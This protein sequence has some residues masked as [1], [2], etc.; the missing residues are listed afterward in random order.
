MFHRLLPFFTLFLISATASAWAQNQLV[1]RVVA[2][3]NDEAITQSELDL[4]LRPMFKE[5]R[6]QYKGDELGRQFNEVRLKLL[7]QMI[8]DRLVFQQAKSQS[9]TVDEEEIDQHIDELKSR[10]PSQEAF[11]KELDEQHY[12]L[13]ELRENYRRQIMI[14]KLHDQEIRAHVVISPRKIE[15]YYKEHQSEFAEE[16]QNKIRSITIRK[17]QEAIDKGILDEAAKKKIESIEK[18]IRAGE[19]F[20]KLAQEFSEDGYAKEGGRVGLVKRNE[21]MPEINDILFQLQAGGISP[22]LETSIGYHLF[23]VEEKKLSR[24]PPFEEVKEKIRTILFRKAAEERF[25]E[26]MNELKTRA[27][28]SIR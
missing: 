17:G 28:I 20:E 13:N 7:D 2:V 27:Y 22:V 14:R 23:K 18:R 15:D 12:N 9:I 26:W 21:M 5:L 6:G 25:R 3:V 24:V 4:Y 8:E 16:E 10:F 11:Q 19:S 1:D